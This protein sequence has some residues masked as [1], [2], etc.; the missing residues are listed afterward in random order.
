MEQLPSAQLSAA[1]LTE[2]DVKRRFVPFL[3]DFYRHRYEPLPNTVEVDFD[4]V[5]EGGVV[6]DGRVQF[7][8]P[9]GKMFTCTY[10]ATSR[11]KAEE[12]KFTLNLQY[13]VWDCAAF[14]A[15]LAAAAYIVFYNARFTWLVALHWPGNIGLLLGMGTIGFLGWYFTMQRWRKYRFIHAIAQFQQYYADDQWIAIAEDVFPSPIDPYLQELRSQCTYQG[16]GLAVVPAEGNVRPLVSPS[17]LNLYGKDRAMVDWVTRAQ[18]YRSATEGMGTLTKVRPP[19]TLQAAWNKIARPVRHLVVEPFKKM[20]WS[21]LAKPFAQASSPYTRFMRGRATQKWIFSMALL[22]VS[23]LM[24]QVMSVREE[25]VADLEALKNWR[26][27]GRNPEDQ[28]GYLIDGEA[29]PYNAEPTGVPKQYPRRADARD[30]TPT[31]DMSGDDDEV[32]TID[33]SG[34]SD[35][36]ANGQKPTANSQQPTRYEGIE[37]EPAPAPR[38]APVV[39]KPAPTATPST[40]KAAPCEQFS[41][42]S[43]WVIQENAF[44]QRGNAEERLGLLQRKKISAEIVARHC[45]DS[46]TSGYVVLL[47]GLFS[48]K[49][50]AQ[51]KL[52]GYVKTYPA[53]GLGKATLLLRPLKK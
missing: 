53:Q 40:Q 44:S 13:F 30:E 26:S 43:G 32:P 45:L 16:F 52:D 3:K 17:R 36:A 14:A 4:S 20:V 18:W 33:L 15:V 47:G 22:L 6:A 2:D 5:G 1:V 19:D 23:P 28:P 51:R 49:T 12:V 27:D 9:D 37:D 21:A 24:Y 38:P 29:I 34:G 10:E 39:K 42:K 25:D 48:E 46:G 11:D 41:G 8:K 7:R 31:I 50:A 35:D